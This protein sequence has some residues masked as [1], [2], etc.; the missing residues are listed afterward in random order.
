MIIQPVVTLPDEI[1]KD[2]PFEIQT[3]FK[4]PSDRNRQFDVTAR[5]NEQTF[6][7][8][9]VNDGFSVNPYLSFF[10]KTSESGVL[11][12]IWQD[13]GGQRFEIEKQLEVS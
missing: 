11:S 2:E 9:K 7:S 3:L 1:K 6:F 8:A 4:N 10:L 12:I 5:F 13:Q